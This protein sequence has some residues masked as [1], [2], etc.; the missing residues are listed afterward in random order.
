MSADIPF[1]LLVAVE[2][3]INEFG[4]GVEFLVLSCFVLVF[5]WM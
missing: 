1:C 3:G 4:V 5:C 2:E